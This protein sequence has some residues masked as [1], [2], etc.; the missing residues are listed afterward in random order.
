MK[1]EREVRLGFPLDIIITKPTLLS[2]QWPSYGLVSRTRRTFCQNHIFL[3]RTQSINK[4]Q[5]NPSNTCLC[6]VPL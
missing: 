3:Y 4:H 6:V 2:K 5:M 1:I